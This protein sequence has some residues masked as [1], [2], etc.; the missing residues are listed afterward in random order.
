MKTYTI[1]KNILCAALTCVVISLSLTGCS[2]EEQK[3]EPAKTAFNPFDHSKD[4]P[5]TPQEKHKFEDAFAAQCVARELK[6]STNPEVD[7]ERFAKPCQC[8][9]NYMVKDLTDEEAEKY[10]DEHE[11]PRSLQIKY[12]SAAFH[13]T[14]PKGLDKGF[15]SYQAPEPKPKEGFFSKLF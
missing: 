8:I 13:C 9:A 4:E 11:N 1:T 2:D 15:K 7:K 5:V 10:L 3:T 12:N 6:N 14:Q